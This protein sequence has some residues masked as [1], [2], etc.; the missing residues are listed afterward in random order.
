MTKL[1]VPIDAKVLYSMY[2]YAAFAKHIHGTEIAGW[3]HYSQK[4]GIYKLA[5]LPKQIVSGAEVDTF[6]AEI[7]RDVKYDISDMVVQ[8]HSHVDMGVYPSSTDKD[9]IKQSM[10]LY[11]LLFSIIVN[12]KNEYS[13]RLDIRRI[14]FGRDTLVLP[15]SDI[16]TYDVVLEPYYA[17]TVVY[18][19][20]KTKCS[21]PRK[22][23]TKRQRSY[24][25]K[26]DN[27]FDEYEDL[28]GVYLP[29]YN[30]T[31]SAPSNPVGN[32]GCGGLSFAV[33]V[34]LLAFALYQEHKA[35]FKMFNVT[36]VK[37]NFFIN[38][39]PSKT[40]CSVSDGEVSV[41]NMKASWQEFLLR[42]GNEKI[43][44]VE[45]FSYNLANINRW[46][47]KYMAKNEVGFPV[48]ESS[49]SSGQGK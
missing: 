9:N 48:V 30:E 15:E 35:D 38:H 16:I 4:E 5:P 14:A 12:C 20:V 7:I 49:A 26:N 23:Y 36:N 45:S 44:Y 46:K 27:A 28:N 2:E 31:P 11:P 17:N 13:A 10:K 39:Q 40:Y 42:C 22:P 3:G 1:V 34:K 6:P 41:N 25:E 37:E 33:G 8:W 47:A 24:Q 18:N 32:P 19:E 43:S 21:T 29:F